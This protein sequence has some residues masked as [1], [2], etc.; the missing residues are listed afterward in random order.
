[1][2]KVI[3]HKPSSETDIYETVSLHYAKRHA[4]L[5]KDDYRFVE[6]IQCTDASEAVIETFGIRP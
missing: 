6:I 4:D 3:L 1:M 2:Y 5:F